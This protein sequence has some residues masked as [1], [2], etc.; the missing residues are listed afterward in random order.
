LPDGHGSWL[1]E[2]GFPDEE[3]DFSWEGGEECEF[4]FLEDG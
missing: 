1:G 4:L 3:A 2:R